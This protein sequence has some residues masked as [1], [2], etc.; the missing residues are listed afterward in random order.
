MKKLAKKNSVT[1][2][3]LSCTTNG[4]AVAKGKSVF[5]SG[6]SRFDLKHSSGNLNVHNGYYY[7]VTKSFVGNIVGHVKVTG[8]GKVF[9][10]NVNANFPN[11]PTIL[12]SVWGY[13]ATY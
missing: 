5:Y 11:T 3:V 12:A 4:L 13:V 10:T 2:G 1:K 6:V 9:K 7:I 8:T